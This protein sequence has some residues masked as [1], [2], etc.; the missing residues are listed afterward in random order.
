MNGN[1]SET[2]I[3][4][5]VF[6]DAKHLMVGW[7]ILAFFVSSVPVSLSQP[8]I[9]SDQWSLSLHFKGLIPNRS[10]FSR[11]PSRDC[12]HEQNGCTGT[13]SASI[14]HMVQC[15]LCL[16][17]HYRKRPE[18]ATAN[19]Y[20]NTIKIIKTNNKT[21]PRGSETE[22][23]FLS[24]RCASRSAVIFRFRRFRQ[25]A[26][27]HK[28][29][30]P[31][32][33]CI[34]SSNM[35]QL[36]LLFLFSSTSERAS[37]RR[38]GALY[39]VF[40]WKWNPFAALFHPNSQFLTVGAHFEWHDSIDCRARTQLRLADDEVTETRTKKCITIHFNCFRW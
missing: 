31:C 16:A 5:L 3:T 13:R 21:H 26:N 39:I 32:T 22:I 24:V 36:P 28:H 34:N 15:A 6:L 38:G 10:V 20:A 12:R 11:L 23:I 40:A 27:A 25:M 37:V 29:M 14:A 17:A 35:T 1:F 9:Q 30:Q 7:R 33:L 2:T 8:S 18:C 4:F 19:Q